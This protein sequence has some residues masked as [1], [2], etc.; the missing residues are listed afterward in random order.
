MKL[1]S[2]KFRIVAL[3]AACVITATGGLVTYSVVSSNS[4]L[5][6]VT[7]NVDGLLDRMTK[8]SLVRLASTQ[9]STIG[10]EVDSAFDAARAMARSLETIV[11]PAEGTASPVD[12]R[13]A[14][15]NGILL[16]VLK[17][18]PRFN[19]T[20]SAWMPN[21]LDGRDK[22]FNGRTEIGSDTTG[23]A[24][25]YWT[26]DANGRIAL[27]PLVEYDSQDLHPNGV[28][29]GGWFIGPMTNGK[30]SILAPLPYIVQGKHV[31]LATMSVPI[32]AGGKFLGVAGA[33]FDL[34][35]VQTLAEKVNAS[36]YEGKGAVTIVS[37]TG[38]VV[39]SSATPGAIGGPLSG[40]KNAVPEDLTVAKSGEATVRVD[41]QSDRL[42][43]FAPIPLGRTGAAWSV[44][45]GVPRSLALADAQKLGDTLSE[46]NRN[47]VFWQVVVALG[48]A[49]IAVVAMGLV[50]Q[51]IA[52][53]IGRLTETLRRLAA[54]EIVKEIDGADRRDEIGDISRAVDQIRIGA[55][56]E[57][58]RK[59]QADEAAR[60]REETERRETMYRLAGE[61]ENAM[62]NVV[63]NVVN[64]STQLRGAATTMV[65]ATT[66]VAHQS[67]AAAAASNEASTNVE[68]VAAAAEEL[69][70]SINEIK[71]QADESA[72]IANSAAVEAEATAARVRELSNA[73]N[74]IGQVVELISNIAGQTNLLALN[75]TIEAARA[76]EAGRGFAVVAA[77]VKGLADQTAKA[78]SEIGQQIGEIQASTQ[79]SVQAIM[80]I[81]QVIERVNN[82]AASIAEAVDQQGAA[83]HEIAH[84]VTQASAG[85]R[86]VTQNIDG[87]TVAVADS[88][89]ASNQVESAAVDLSHQSETLRSVMDDFLKT[90]RAA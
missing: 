8:E 66:K 16:R 14:Q 34:A 28:M 50:A 9:A 20:Y 10:T 83:T 15:L 37:N 48:V 38:L 67:T 85:T 11:D 49:A 42:K 73:A 36:I 64:S 60:V 59:S 46:R 30:E 68:T 81:T 40:V 56:E 29:K 72:G 26:R 2:I 1:S 5:D 41:E 51:G 82:I 7:R 52:G 43:V 70:T 57:A 24:L 63:R 61:F 87:I 80:G 89:A 21:A 79:A 25:P 84:N 6:H 12:S 23:R 13:R 47:D 27:Q 62:G 75:A 33:D 4:T 58:R 54:G 88:T 31:F 17:D 53:P 76:G 19:G 90:V 18:N 74:R 71:R 77:E 32:S 65:G 22:D 35:F 3:S 39:A 69:A 86:E 45:I 55:E 78:T 44:I